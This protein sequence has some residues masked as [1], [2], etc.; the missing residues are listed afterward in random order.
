MA[1]K[2]R[3]ISVRF[4]GQIRSLL[5]GQTPVPLQHVIA[6]TPALERIRI[7]HADFKEMEAIP[8][9]LPNLKQAD[10]EL[11]IRKFKKWSE[12]EL[13][14]QFQLRGFGHHFA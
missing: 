11:V 13:L 7:M 4:G 6:H 5:L 8:Q 10:L 14:E 3:A 2:L 9:M 12:L 1:V